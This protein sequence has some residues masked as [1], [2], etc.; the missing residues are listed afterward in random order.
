MDFYFWPIIKRFI[1]SKAPKTEEELKEVIDDFF[2]NHYNHGQLVKS[3]KFW[4]LKRE[5]QHFFEHPIW[6]DPA[7]WMVPNTIILGL[8]KVDFWF[9]F[10]S[11]LQD[12]AIIKT[13]K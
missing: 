11:W 9:C 3:V 2:E 4:F 7:S 6:G 12:K 13:S 5:S 10:L 1:R 8:F